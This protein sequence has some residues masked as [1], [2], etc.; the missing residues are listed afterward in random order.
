METPLT[1]EYFEETLNAT[2]DKRAEVADKK[3]ETVLDKRFEDFARI[4]AEGFANTASKEE[5][6]RLESRMA[7]KDDVAKLESRIATKDDIA[8]VRH[9]ISRVATDVK[10]LSATVKKQEMEYV[11]LK[12]KVT[13]LDSRISQ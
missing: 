11:E 7:T 3:W 4:I 12:L 1:K 13:E 8:A 5:L 9:D 2:L 10:E 6:T